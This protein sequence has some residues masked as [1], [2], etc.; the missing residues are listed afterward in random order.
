MKKMVLVFLAISA[1]VFAE[2]KLPKIFGN[3]MVL[4][5]HSV[6][7]IWG[8]ANSGERI[9]V[10]IVD[11]KAECIA[12]SNGKWSI[13]LSQ[14]KA[15]GPF[16]L[17]IE[18]KNKITL[19]NV[20][21]GE[22]WLCSGQSNM[23]YQLRRCTGSEEEIGKASYP[24][25]R[26]FIVK[27]NV[28]ESPLNDVEGEWLL[29]DPKNIGEFSGVG[30]FFGK[31][32]FEELNVPI[33]LIQATWGGTPAEAW[34]AKN[35]LEPDEDFKPIL[36][37]WNKQVEE[38]PT[39][40]EEW[41]RNKD[42]LL[43]KW[44]ADSLDAV[45]KGAARPRKPKRPELGTKNQPGGLYNGMIYPLVP[46][47]F[48]GVIW[49]QGESNAMR[50]YQ[51]RKLF[52]ALI[53]NWRA[54]WGRNELPFYFVQLPNL[55]RKAAPSQSG[56]AELREAQLKTLSLHN[57]GMAVTID[58]GDSTNLHPANKTEVGLRLALVALYN[59]YHRD[60]FFCSGP[61]FKSFKIENGKVI[62]SFNH[63][64]VGLITKDGK[65][66]RGFK[67]CGEDKVFVDANAEIVA[68]NVVVWCDTI[69]NPVAVRYAWADNPQ[70][71]L[72]NSAMLPASPFRTDDWPEV[73]FEKW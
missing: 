16:D 25:I 27:H 55:I 10:H 52:P 50:A 64:G 59:V 22:V 60:E 12:D 24:L 66:L 40:L 65:K 57:T 46:L 36:A 41:N 7:K 21:V 54:V 39:E 44:S 19:S 29:C 32:L 6:I 37:R 43:K 4:Q 58:I 48:Q 13:E 71:N 42:N 62:V 67:I 70:C 34:T 45:A 28:A 17:V 23:E 68:N 20:M 53:N 2:V 47:S 30:F 15:G 35:I 18:G 31:K 33:G 3:N 5:Q 61:I 9:K 73:T 72:Y 14:M 49:Y 63:T 56:W 69:I 38:Y 8:F 26:I 1:T 51:Y 11:N